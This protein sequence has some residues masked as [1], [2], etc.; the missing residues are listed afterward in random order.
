[1][2]Q[3][4]LAEALHLGKDGKR[5]VRR[6]E[7]GTRAISGPVKVAVEFMRAREEPT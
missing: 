4:Q 3:A 5:A 7:A 6:W 1:M 2:T